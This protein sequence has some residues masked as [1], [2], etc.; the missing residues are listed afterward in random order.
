MTVDEMFNVGVVDTATLSYFNDF[1]IDRQ[2]IPPPGANDRYFHIAY[3]LTALKDLPDVRFFEVIDYDVPNTVFPEYED[4]D[5]W[6]APATDYVWTKDDD[7]FQ[8]GFTGNVPSD[9]HGV[10]VYSFDL[11]DDWDDGDLNG[12]NAYSNVDSVVG[13]QWNIGDM[14]QGETWQLTITFWFGVPA[15]EPEPPPPISAPEF[16]FSTPIMTSVVA[17]VYL[18]LRKRLSK[19][20][21]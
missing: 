1:S 18:F 14:N 3:T 7:Y 13:L 21:E 19:R 6:Y 16:V 10:G 12:N 9:N 11:D 15:G 17:A 20:K 2:V 5:G 8:N 4:D